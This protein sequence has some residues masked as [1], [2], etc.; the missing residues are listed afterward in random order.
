MASTSFQPK[1]KSPS[2]VI[3]FFKIIHRKSLQ[4]GTLKIPRKFSRIY[5]SSVP[6]PV[7]LKLPDGTQWKIDWTN[8][9]GEIIFK[10][11]WKEF[12]AY[13]SLDQGHLL[14]FD[15]KKTSLFEVHIF[16]TSCLEINYPPNDHTDD[17][18]VE[19]LNKPPSPLRGDLR[20]RSV[21]PLSTP[22]KT[23]RLRSATKSRDVERGSQSKDTSLEMPVFS[24]PRQ[25]FLDFSPGTSGFQA[26]KEAEKFSSENP[27]CIVKIRQAIRSNRNFPAS[28]FIKYFKNEEQKVKISFEGKL[29]PAKLR[30]YRQ[31]STAFISSGWLQFA[32][33]SKL[34]PGDVT[35]FELVDRDDP[36]FETHI[37]RAKAFKSSSCGFQ[38]LKAA[39]NFKSENPS[40]MVKITQTNL[41]R[42]NAAIPVPFF[43][44]YFAKKKP[45]IQIKLRNKLLPAKLLYYPSSSAAYISAGWQAF[46][47]ASN[48]KAGDVCVF[49]LVN[50][51]DRVLD[52]HIYRAGRLLSF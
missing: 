26:L 37:Y 11:G 13:Y 50:E 7:Y 25:D 16:D 36:V 31:N 27:F 18:C 10:N 32:Q 49:E 4:A 17:D 38:S 44:K 28:F 12:A 8:H 15:Y 35:V 46:V 33:A 20:K 6:N 39:R 21:A 42:T 30:Y 52:V 19:I 14:W 5:G 45:N 51:K 9:D 48:L 1:S 47:G 24:S 34:Q 3:S 2:T 41:P 22:S 43:T 29:F 23:K 40:F